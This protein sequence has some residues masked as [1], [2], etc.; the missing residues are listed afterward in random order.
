[1]ASALLFWACAA[2]SAALCVTVEFQS[3]ELQ[4]SADCIACS[5][6]LTARAASARLA[7][8]SDRSSMIAWWSSST[9][10]WST[11]PVRDETWEAPSSS[12]AGGS[13]PAAAA[14]GGGGAGDADGGRGSSIDSPAD[15]SELILLRAD[16][17]M[18]RGSTDGDTAEEAAAAA[19]LD[20]DRGV[21]RPAPPGPAAPFGAT[22]SNWSSSSAS[23][24][25]G[26]SAGRRFPPD[27]VRARSSAPRDA[28]GRG[29]EDGCGTGSAAAGG[30]S[31]ARAACPGPGDGGG[32][33]SDTAAE[34]FFRCLVRDGV[35]IIFLADLAAG[36]PTRPPSRASCLFSP[37][38]SSISGTPRNRAK[39]LAN[40]SR[41]SAVG[42]S[43]SRLSFSLTHVTRLRSRPDGL[44]FRTVRSVVRPFL[45]AT[46]RSSGTATAFFFPHVRARR[47][48]G[49]SWD[50]PSCPAGSYSS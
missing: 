20:L 34:S 17:D 31:S 7:S 11:P 26:V 3:D 22:F 38:S 12:F 45:T 9:I 40:L 10:S 43:M 19:G 4:F 6:T 32:P 14:A 41:S 29:A 50:G 37:S 49:P 33:G 35:R 44:P 39:A 23:S 47:D 46:N 21:A 42:A 28:A 24:D 48:R 25:P 2:A 8:S 15:G 27:G 18:P 16:S 13:S 30:G 1:M 36:L 5:A